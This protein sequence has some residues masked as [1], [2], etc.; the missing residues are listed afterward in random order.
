MLKTIQ[1]LLGA[2]SPGGFR[3][4][5]GPVMLKVAPDGE[6]LQPDYLAEA[7]LSLPPQPDLTVGCLLFGHQ[8]QLSRTT[9]TV[10]PPPSRTGD[11]LEP[12]KKTPVGGCAAPRQ[13]RE[14]SSISASSIRTYSDLIRV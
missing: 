10:A 11:C 4:D 1:Q 5:L 7:P 8:V 3:C 14:P 2:Q 9:N 12:S 13:S 6:V